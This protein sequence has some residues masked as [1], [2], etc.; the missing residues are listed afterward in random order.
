M[1]Y[2]EIIKDFHT[3]DK[4]K[5]QRSGKQPP[6][7]IMETKR[8]KGNKDGKTV[9][10]INHKA[11][12]IVIDNKEYREKDFDKLFPNKYPSFNIKKVISTSKDKQIEYTMYMYFPVAML[13][14]HK[15]KVICRKKMT[16]FIYEL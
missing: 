11:F 6:E 13:K 12:R 5:K 7:I 15:V 14:E 2:K 4:P 9:S 3:I 10:L 16:Q 1:A 8:P